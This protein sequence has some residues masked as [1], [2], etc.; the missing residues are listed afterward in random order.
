MLLSTLPISGRSPDIIWGFPFILQIMVS[1]WFKL[2]GEFWKI[3][4]AVTVLGRWKRSFPPFAVLIWAAQK[5]WGA[6]ADGW[7][8]WANAL[9]R[10][11]SK[12]KMQLWKCGA[13][14]STTYSWWMHNVTHLVP[15]QSCSEMEINSFHQL[16]TV[17]QLCLLRWIYSCASDPRRACSVAYACGH[18]KYLYLYE[19]RLCC[20]ALTSQKH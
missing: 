1:Q 8:L 4:P 17:R 5:G 14:N 20:S 9:E 15:H 3:L 10:R 2:T 11:P 12:Y 13:L 6:R 16:N 18:C 7:L 19:V